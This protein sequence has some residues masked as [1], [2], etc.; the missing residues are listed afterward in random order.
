MQDALA[1][2]ILPIHLLFSWRTNFA[3]PPA[4]ARYC[5]VLSPPASHM[6]HSVKESSLE[7][8][9]S[10][11]SILHILLL[12]QASSPALSIIPDFTFITGTIY[13][14]QS[15]CPGQTRTQRS[16]FCR[17]F[18]NSSPSPLSSSSPSLLGVG[19]SSNTSSKDSFLPRQDPLRASRAARCRVYRSFHFGD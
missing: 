6:L 3:L 8:A 17:L 11:R 7:R 10:L 18:T 19:P 14:T 9:V 13:Q 1:V 2:R 16:P 4:A 12:L 15:I 5:H